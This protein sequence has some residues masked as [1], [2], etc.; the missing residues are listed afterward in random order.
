MAAIGRLSSPCPIAAVI[1]G[2][3]VMKEWR[4][5]L[6]ILLLL[7]FVARVLQLLAGTVPNFL[8]V[9]LH[10]VPP[11]LFALIHGARLY[12]WRG[13]L[14]LAVLCL[15]FSVLGGRLPFSLV[16]WG[17]SSAATREEFS[18]NASKP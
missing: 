16:A 14:V 10:V 6:W 11:A 5:L 15:G 7:Y 1:E 8:I 4:F 18:G 9:G 3:L 12:G 17:A 13:I 2:R